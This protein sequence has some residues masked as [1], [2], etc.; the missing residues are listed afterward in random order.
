[1]SLIQSTK[2]KFTRPPASTTRYV[3]L[4]T[5]TGTAVRTSE[6]R[7]V[8][9]ALAILK[10]LYRIPVCSTDQAVQYGRTSTGTGHTKI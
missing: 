6:S 3:L 1:M 9:V 7:R 5:S 10:L 8:S 4:H 2:F